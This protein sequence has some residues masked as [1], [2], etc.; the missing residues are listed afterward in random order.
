M[1]GG[2][3]GEGLWG[4]G[5]G[6]ISEEETGS[7][8][9]VSCGATAAAAAAML[10]FKCATSILVLADALAAVTAAPSCTPNSI[11]LCTHWN[12]CLL[13]CLCVCLTVFVY[14]LLFVCV[15]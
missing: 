6:V 5:V 8:G 13:A 12:A 4:V 9:T 14:V 3:G 15:D 1:L 7:C 11:L 2:W 10:E